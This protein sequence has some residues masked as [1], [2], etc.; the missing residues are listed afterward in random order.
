M[1]VDYSTLSEEKK[2][3]ARKVYA[4]AI[5]Y[6]LDP[7]FVIPMVMAESS[8]V[9]GPSGR[10][11]KD[12][13]PVSF[14]VM[15]MIPGTAARYGVPDYKNVTED[16]NIDAGMRHLKD[17]VDNPKIG[18]SPK[19][20]IAAF[21]AGSATP[22]IKTGEEKDLQPETAAHLGNI[23]K[24]IGGDP[25]PPV[26]EAT[27]IDFDKLEQKADSKPAKNQYDDLEHPDAIAV[28]YDAVSPERTIVPGAL[29]GALTGATISGGKNIVAPIVN[30]A[31]RVFGIEKSEP[32]NIGTRAEPVLDPTSPT[33]RA[34]AVSESAGVNVVDPLDVENQAKVLAEGDETPGGKWREKTGFGKG[35]GTVQ[36]V[37]LAGRRAANKGV[38]SSK[39]DKMYG[40]R[41]A[42]EPAAIFDRLIYR[43]NQREAAQAEAIKQAAQ[44][45][46]VKQAAQAEAAKQA[47]IE[48][49]NLRERQALESRAA[50]NKAYEGSWGKRIATTVGDVFRGGLSGAA[51]GY[52][53]QAA[54]NAYNANN[55][56]EAA[57]YGLA[58]GLSV[59]DLLATVLPNAAK[60]AAQKITGPLAVV[61]TT[62]AN[63]YHDIRN[64]DYAGA[65]GD[66]AIGGS[67]FIPGVGLPV[68][69]YLDWVKNNPE[70][71]ANLR[72]EMSGYAN[73]I[74]P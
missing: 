25:V 60:T 57:A 66:A 46:A 73:F 8:F 36:D 17:L 23:N 22:Y 18:N 34:Q 55:N 20:V 21:N 41:Q 4:S 44:A 35:T 39:L 12:G 71:A 49:E 52:N 29:L 67:L 65:A 31:G 48:S 74:G 24:I 5:K 62:G 15:P 53:A 16:D 42:G 14:G 32:V 61:G 72:D 2:A 45:E 64:K 33:A 50:A 26:K 63:M 38:F 10:K 51:A 69:A 13:T 27:T 59:A 3:V 6:G 56:P 54:Q 40:A 30:A 58:S 47:A 28:T 11:N 1:A 70:K 37:V 68:S 43:Q 7:E 9:H 19:K